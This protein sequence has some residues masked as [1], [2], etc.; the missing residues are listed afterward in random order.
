MGYFVPNDR[1][2]QVR[3][4]VVPGDNVDIQIQESKYYSFFERNK[5]EYEIQEE[6]NKMVN[7]GED[8][9]VIIETINKRLGHEMFYVDDKTGEIQRFFD[10]ERAETLEEQ[11]ARILKNKP[12]P[13]LP[14]SFELT[15]LEFGKRYRYEKARGYFRYTKL[16]N[17][18]TRMYIAYP[19]NDKFYLRILL[20]H[21]KGMTDVDDLLLGPQGDMKYP[22]YKLACLAWD[23]I[24][25]SSEYYMTMHE[26]WRLG[27]H[28]YKLLK[29]F[30]QIIKEGT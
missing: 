18:V 16:Q 13:K 2:V 12:A 23:L 20:K 4:N 21:R 10:Y 25:N 7:D 19:G 17:R 29:F 6:F 5:L 26:C 11:H 14:W 9:Q 28:G 3:K 15:Y 24:D 22:S 8:H 30:A 27:C 1:T